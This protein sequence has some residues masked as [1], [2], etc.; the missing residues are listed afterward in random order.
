MKVYVKVLAKPI[1]LF[2][3][4]SEVLSVLYFTDSTFS[5]CVPM[6]HYNTLAMDDWSLQLTAAALTFGFSTHL[7]DNI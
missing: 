6:W 3:H 5:G 7:A 1:C 4:L 2:P